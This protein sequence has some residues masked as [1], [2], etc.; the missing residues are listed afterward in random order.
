MDPNM[1]KIGRQISLRMGVTLSLCLSFT[2]SLFGQL[3]SKEGFNLQ[4]FIISFLLSFIVS[5]FISLLIGVFVPMKKVTDNYKEKHGLKP[6][7]L[8]TILAESFISDIIYTPVIT[9]VMTIMNYALAIHKGAK[10]PVP[11]MVIG[12]VESLLLCFVVGYVL[13]FFFMPLYMRMVFEKNGMKM[14]GRDS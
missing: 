2:G 12:M 13:I 14:G 8:K 3:S 4:A 9:I 11:A 6:G 10:I 1:K 5:F 7:G